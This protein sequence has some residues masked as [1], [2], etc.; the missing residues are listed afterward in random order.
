MKALIVYSGKY[1]S[2]KQ[3]SEWISEDLSVPAVP[4]KSVKDKDIAAV[5]TVILGSSVMMGSLTMK[6]W[7]KA[8][9][10][11]A[12]EGK[13]LI[14]FSV[15]GTK[16]TDQKGNKDILEQSLSPEMISKMKFFPLYGRIRMSDLPLLL[17]PLIKAIEKSKKDAEPGATGEFDGV[18]RENIAPIVSAARARA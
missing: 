14:L 8:H 11:S 18:K 2:T 4:I 5:D 6:G 16:P 10:P 3:Y 12:L 13:R 7:L 17:R 15:S 1:G 9:W